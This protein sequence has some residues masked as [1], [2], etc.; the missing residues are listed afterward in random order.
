MRTNHLQ[1]LRFFSMLL[2]SSALLFSTSCKK[3]SDEDPDNEQELITTVILTFTGGGTIITAVARDLDG[4]GGN[5][6][7]VDNI[8][9]AANTDYALTIAFLDES[10]PTDV[11]DITEE[12][13]EE[14][15]EH[16]VCFVATGAMPKPTI[17]DTD[18]DG[19]P[20]GLVSTLRTGA[21]G[22]GTLR[23]TLKHEPD[24]NAADPC[25]TGDTDVEQTFSVT[26]Q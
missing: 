10:D 26:I 20:L 4:D 9:L 16:L 13:L 14:A 24:K 22:N 12:V 8:T 18:D 11:E 7:V 21:A 15:D 6:P 2:L 25:A 23:V 17:Q 1:L 3:D 5:P 19:K